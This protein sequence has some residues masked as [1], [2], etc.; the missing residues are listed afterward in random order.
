MVMFNTMKLVKKFER[1]FIGV[2]D[3]LF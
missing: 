3:A 1:N 2:Y